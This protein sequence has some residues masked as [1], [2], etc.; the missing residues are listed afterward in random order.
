M[1]GATL[2]GT[3][4]EE[5]SGSVTPHVEIDVY[6]AGTPGV[7]AELETDGSGRFGPIELPAGDYRLQIAKANFQ[8][9]TQRLTIKENVE[10]ALQ[11]V[12]LGVIAGSVKNSQ[13]EAVVGALVTA[14]PKPPQGEPLRPTPNGHPA[15]AVDYGGNYRI[16][17]LAPGE[18]A[19]I[20]TYGNANRLAGRLWLA[21]MSPSLGHGFQTYPPNAPLDY[22]AVRSGETRGGVDFK[23]DPR[24]LR[25]LQ[26]VV[27]PPAVLTRFGIGLFRVDQPSFSIDQANTIPGQT[28]T[29]NG[30]APGAYR[31]AASRFG[32]AANSVMQPNGNVVPVP[33]GTAAPV[34]EP[35]F[36]EAL[37]TI[38]DQ[39]V[40]P[41]TLRPVPGRAARFSLSSGQGCPAE[42]QLTLTPRENWGP[43]GGR[44][45]RVKVG[46][47][48]TLA[49]LAPG[50]YNV[51]VTV[52]NQVCVGPAVKFDLSR[53]E[54]EAPIQIT[55]APAPTEN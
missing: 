26:V 8:P 24:P 32:L 31:L 4:R 29:F 41:V 14:V 55:I 50:V 34:V 33:A 48:L 35:L 19:V 16:S 22:L 49:G 37:V 28:V 15:A 3:V 52:P 54:P 44:D 2:S 5:R 13:G 18:Y 43:D 40:P 7:V 12:R 42:A 38:G 23:L 6:R 36:A 39:N 21:D 46:E 20:M 10:L 11:L 1:F 17:G 9:M 51:R 45:A 30:L 53:G 25:S 47:V 27:E